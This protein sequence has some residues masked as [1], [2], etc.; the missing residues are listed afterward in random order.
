MANKKNHHKP[1]E[2]NKK[3]IV[4]GILASIAIIIVAAVIYWIIESPKT[5]NINIVVAPVSAKIKIGDKNFRNGS[6]K[7]E[8]GTY[9]VSISKDGFGSYTGQITIADGQTEKLY[10]CLQKN[11]NNEDYYA[12]HEEDANACWQVEE[13]NI[14]KLEGEKYSDKIFK[15]APFHSY[16]RGFYIDPY[17]DDEDKVH[18]K[19]TIAT[20]IA[21]RAEGLK[22]NAH[23]WLSQKGININDYP[24]EYSSCAYGD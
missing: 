11:E 2:I 4:V 20:C 16:S 12:S 8:P 3:R 21:E 19:I 13:Y 23:E 5:G 6:H 18:V 14:E 22:Q 10:I 15:V 17:L 9:D 1:E 7:I 24:V